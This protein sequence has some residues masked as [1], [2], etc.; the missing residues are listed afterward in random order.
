M[1]LKAQVQNL[2]RQYQL[3]KPVK[4]DISC[5]HVTAIDRRVGMNRAYGETFSLN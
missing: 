4:I 1:L 5:Q 3:I 2:P